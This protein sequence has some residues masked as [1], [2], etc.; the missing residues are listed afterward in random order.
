MKR[1]ED[2]QPYENNP[3]LNDKAVKYVKK[4]IKRFGFKNPIIV[5][6][7]GVIVA[8]HT[9]YKASLELGLETVPVI[10]ADDLTEKQ[11]KAYRLADNKTAEH[12]EWDFNVLDAE[13]FDL[14]PSFDMSDF[15]FDVEKVMEDGF[16]EEFSLP[17]DDKPAMRTITLT[18]CE[19]QYSIVMKAHDWIRDNVE[20]L[21]SFDGKNDKSNMIFEAVYEWAEQKRLV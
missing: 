20:T 10:I 19:E 1:L 6:S 13:L 8:G 11:I 15:G 3:R 7:D 5:D 17:D 14:S 16:G 9:R 12:A 21:H 4:S 18:L 2:I